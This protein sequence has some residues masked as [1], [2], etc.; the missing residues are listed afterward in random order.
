M[1]SAHGNRFHPLPNN[2]VRV[3]TAE[4][5]H[6]GAPDSM[7]STLNPTE[8][9]C[10]G[11]IRYRNSIGRVRANLLRF[12][13]LKLSMKAHLQTPSVTPH[14]DS[15]ITE[16]PT[17]VNEIQRQGSAGKLLFQAFLPQYLDFSAGQAA[18]SSK[19][20]TRKRFIWMERVRSILRS[21]PRSVGPVKVDAIPFAEARP[22]RPT[23]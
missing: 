21:S 10:S 5:A 12:I 18:L 3:R 14:K 1:A 17:R 19:E 9:A 7:E 20:R 13:D 11:Q 8:G 4:F 16:S 22:V 6:R 15:R 23:R 2:P